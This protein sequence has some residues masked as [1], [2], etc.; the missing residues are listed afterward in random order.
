MTRQELIDY[1]SSLQPSPGVASANSVATPVT[2]SPQEAAV[3]FAFTHWLADD[4][5]DYT[6]NPTLINALLQMSGNNTN[7]G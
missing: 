5:S 2:I 4:G 7:N 3:D 6:T 1:L